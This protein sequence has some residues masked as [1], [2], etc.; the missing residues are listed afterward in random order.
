MHGVVVVAAGEAV[1]LAGGRVRQRLRG[2]QVGG[3]HGTPAGRGVQLRG[4]V[5][6]VV[7]VAAEV[8]GLQEAARV[9]RERGCRAVQ[10]LQLRWQRQGVANWRQQVC[11]LV[12][13]RLQ[14]R[15]T[16]H[17]TTSRVTTYSLRGDSPDLV[18]LLEHNATV[19]HTSSLEPGAFVSGLM[20]RA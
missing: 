12:Q 15:R 1:R 9:Q 8:V 6:A 4:L 2:G 14:R 19:S 3:V 13:V 7:A 20:L 5:M 10:V 16:L 11:Q 18:L 17:N